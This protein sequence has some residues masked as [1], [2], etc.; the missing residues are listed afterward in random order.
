MFLGQGGTGRDSLFSVGLGSKN[1]PF[2]PDPAL[3]LYFLPTKAEE[4]NEANKGVKQPNC[5]CGGS[6]GALQC[7]K[8]LWTLK[9]QMSGNLL[10]WLDHF[11]LETQITPVKWR[12]ISTTWLIILNGDTQPAM[13]GLRMK[14]VN[15][16]VDKAGVMMLS[17]RQ[18][19]WWQWTNAIYYCAVYGDDVDNDENLMTFVQVAQQQRELHPQSGGFAEREGDHTYVTTTFTAL[20]IIIII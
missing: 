6:L 4:T 19:Q 16:S 15:H 3:N 18:P 13:M 7:I 17:R 5:E 12:K 10:V 1:L 20:H 11:S 9:D 2:C 14:A 8:S